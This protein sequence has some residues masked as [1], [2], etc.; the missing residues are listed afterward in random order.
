M[1]YDKKPNVIYDNIN[2]KWRVGIVFDPDNG[3]N[4]VSFVN[5]NWTFVGGSHVEYIADQITKKVIE[6]IKQKKENKSLNIKASQIREHLTFFID[7]NIVKPSFSSQT[8]GEMTTKSNNFGSTC[9][10]DEK[11]IK[12]VINTGLAT[13]VTKLAQSKASLGLKTTDGKK[14]NV[15]NIP[16]LHDA[17]LA[18]TRRS[19][20]CM[21]FL[22]EGDS[23]LSFVLA[24]M[25]ILNREKFGA[26]PLKGKLLNV[27]NATYKQLKENEEFC[28]LKNILGLKQGETYNDVSKLRYGSIGIVTDQDVDGSHIKGLIINMFEY[29]W[30]DLLKIDGF[31]KTISTP[32][33]KIYRKNDAKKQNPK[34]FYSLAEF[35]EWVEIQIKSGE[36]TKWNKPKYYKGLGTSTEK[37]AKDIFKDYTDRIVAFIWDKNVNGEN[38]NIE[39]I[40][41]IEELEEINEISKIEDDEN[42]SMSSKSSKSSKI[43]KISKSKKL[44]KIKASKLKII[45]NK[46]ISNDKITLAFEK[47]RADDRKEWINAHD[48]HNVLE[49]NKQ[50][51]TYG[52]FIDKDL[53]HFSKMDVERSIP[54]MVDSF[55]PSHRK[56]FY[57]LIKKKQKSEIKVAQLG[58]YVAEHTAYKHGEKSIEEAIIGMAQNFTGSNNVYL[59]HPSGNFG[60]RRM[61]GAEHASSR[62]IFTYLNPIARKIYIE[63]DDCILKYQEDEGDMIEPESYYPIIPMILINGSKGIGTG[64]S[65]DVPQFNIIDI[66]ENIIRKLDG[67]EMI[68]IHPW[69]YGFKGEIIDLGEYKYKITGNFNIIDYETILIT[70]IP[71]KGISWTYKYD[72]FLQTLKYDEK[73]N[74]NGK[75][76][77]ILSNSG[78][79]DINFKLVFVSGEL[80]NLIKN[81][82]DGKTEIEKYLKLSVNMGMTNMWL[83]NDK[84]VITHYNN[85]LEIMEE[86]YEVRLEKYIERKHYYLRIL[87]NELEILKNKVRFIN[88][89]INDKITINKKTKK[90]II[91]KLKKM[92]YPKLSS[93]LNAIDPD[94]DEIQDLEDL[95]DLEKSQDLED[96]KNLEKENI[97]EED[98][99][100]KKGVVYKSYDYITS[101]PLFSLTFEKIEK[102]TKE[103]LEKEKEVHDYN[104]TTE[105][106]M[107]RRELKNLMDYYPSWIAE[108]EEED[109]D[110]DNKKKKSVKKSKK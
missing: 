34:E 98:L 12:M 47:T 105:K 73:K 25:K 90:S 64:W 70:E 4:Q 86:F 2:S 41:E 28:N 37:E 62:Y 55:K 89:V 103:L 30:P 71:I 11:F 50:F 58:A 95:E 102:L 29:F 19:K 104:S 91:M 93:K 45:K 36:V 88:D 72:E 61:G 52:E 75:L 63:Q 68:V 9:E 35:E 87:N 110:T 1:H 69:Y 24:G 67:D 78:N 109:D 81:S 5:G 100:N 106:Q 51:V 60:H 21:L 13:L 6:N 14:T 32:L 96:N 23:A 8:K 80:Q 54:Y 94:N 44:I 42:K 56:I 33:V 82:S 18:G 108:R 66:C 43:S 38:E 74:P 99:K 48:K 27:R 16:K 77:N 22:T 3:G 40:E 26:F 57:G 79:N 31:I 46:S 59:L 53:I 49:Y 85:P 65:T 20:E 15:C 101:M 84:G 7:C 39:N 17:H 83:Y 10:L 107:W 92:K 97:D 76:L